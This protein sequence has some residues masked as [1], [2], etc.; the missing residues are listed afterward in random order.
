MYVFAGEVVDRKNFKSEFYHFE[1][2][3]PL[4]IALYIADVVGKHIP[5]ILI[6]VH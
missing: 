4:V 6:P 5:D 2:E 3:N 1:V